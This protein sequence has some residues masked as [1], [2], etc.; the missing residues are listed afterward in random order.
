MIQL[1]LLPDVKQQYI[2]AQRQRR[3][4]TSVSIIVMV[5][6]VVILALLF[7]YNLAL[8]KHLHD[9]NN[10]IS[11]NSQQL[12]SEPHINTI[13]TVQNQLESLPALDSAN[14][15]VSRLFQT[16]LNELTPADISISNFDADTTQK[17]I[18][19]TGSSDSL[20]SVNQYVDV[21][22]KT[23]YSINNEKATQP[24]F[25]DIVLSNFGLSS[26]PI[27]PAQ[28]A[29]YTIT[30]DYD[31]AILNVEYNVTLQVPS[32]TTRA[33]VNVPT[34]LFQSLQTNGAPTTTGGGN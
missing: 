34:S 9:L 1:N 33:D 20:S 24:A 26:D 6:S 3:M 25:S 13:L 17:Q 21:I 23:T 32:I 29:T 14:P 8:K 31:P 7:G 11:S 2:K 5:V 28:A 27:N 12:K 4:I 10:D 19:I 18:T 16:Y 30:F 22:K 15:A